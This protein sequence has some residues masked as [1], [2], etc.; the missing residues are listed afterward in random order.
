MIALSFCQILLTMAV[1]GNARLTRQGR[2][3]VN[4]AG[5]ALGNVVGA[6]VAITMAWRGVGTWSLVAQTLLTYGIRTS[7]IVAAAPFRP[8]LHFSLR[9]LYPHLAMGGSII[10]T[11]LADTGG[12]TGETTLISRLV[13]TGFVGAYSFANQ[14]PRFI[15]ESVSNALWSLL[16]AHALSAEDDAASLRVYGLVL[17]LLGLTVFPVVALIA[18]EARPLVHILLGD[19]WLP[20]VL[21]F[22][23]LL[24]TLALNVAGGLGGALLYAKGRSGIQLSIMVESVLLRLGCA[25][26]VPWIGITGMTIGFGLAN[27][28]VCG[29]GLIAVSRFFRIS[30]VPFLASIAGPAAVSI[31]AGVACWVIGRHLPEGI[32][33]VALDMA[34]CFAVFVLV[35]VPVER[36]RLSQE[37]GML[38]KL[39]RA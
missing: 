15:C 10:G 27:V 32:T 2:L 29:R 35:L 16:Y 36:R 38:R 3:G 37:F 22:Q 4:S 23:V 6:A 9:D 13:G 28:Y 25:A 8:A 24:V 1:P 18:A 17:R 7:F 19:K 21:L 30:P 11:R 26:S 20:A 31:M 14:A 34:A 33:Y 39:V 5:E 12:R